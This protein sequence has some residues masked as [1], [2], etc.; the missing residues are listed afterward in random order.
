MLLQS[1]ELH[2]FPSIIVL[3][4]DET[5]FIRYI[6]FDGVSSK[7]ACM[8]TMARLTWDMVAHHC[9]VYRRLMLVNVIASWHKTA[10]HTCTVVCN[11]SNYSSQQCIVVS[12]INQICL[13][14]FIHMDTLKSDQNGRN[15]AEGTK[16]S[17]TLVPKD[18]SENDA[19]LVCFRLL[20][21]LVPKKVN[22]DRNTYDPDLWCL[23]VSITSTNWI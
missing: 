1:S 11:A 18:P 13:S 3:T 6:I 7:R 22:H 14:T 8:M 15:G 21:C 20:K 10:W 4:F 23:M 5:C 9:W 17:P 19:A 16:I 2:D 12:S